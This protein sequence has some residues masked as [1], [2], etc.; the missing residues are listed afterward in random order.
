MALDLAGNVA[1]ATSTGG[2]TGKRG[3]RVRI[4]ITTNAMLV[5]FIIDIVKNPIFVTIS[6]SWKVTTTNAMLVVVII[7]DIVKNSIFVTI[8]FSWKVGDSPLAGSGGYA[9]SR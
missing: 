8:S 6:F 3:G 7:I 4:V 5:V 2:I 9:D 1:S